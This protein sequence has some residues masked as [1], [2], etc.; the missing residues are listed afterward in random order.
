MRAQSWRCSMMSKTSPENKSSQQRR[1]VIWNGTRTIKLDFAVKVRVMEN[2]HRNLAPGIIQL[3]HLRVLDGDVLFNVLAR[4]LN[5]LVFPLSIHAVQGPVRDSGGYASKDEQKEI[6]LEPAT[7]DEGKEGLED[8]RSDEDAYSKV[9]VVEGAVAFCE[10]YKGS[11]FYCGEAGDPHGGGRR[12]HGEIHK[13]SIVLFFI[14]ALRLILFAS[15]G[16]T[17]FKN[18]GLFPLAKA[19]RGVLQVWDVHL[20]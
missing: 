17:L 15:V 6:G 18:R 4:K 1:R 2:L 14:Q 19:E 13:P 5:L 10:A 16:I 8:V 11:I 3:L 7:V 9:V 20:V 12:G